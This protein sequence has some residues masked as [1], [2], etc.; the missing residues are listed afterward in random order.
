MEEE[1]KKGEN[2]LTQFWYQNFLQLNGLLLTE[3]K[4]NIQNHLFLKKVTKI[5][6]ILTGSNIVSVV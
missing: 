2:D 3:L 5:T 4:H 6:N 1:G